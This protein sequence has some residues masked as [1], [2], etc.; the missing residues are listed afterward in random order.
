[1]AKPKNRPSPL[2][3]ANSIII[4]DVV[5]AMRVQAPLPESYGVSTSSEIGSPF[6]QY[7]TEGTISKVLALSGSST[8][9]GILTRK[10]FLA[11][12]QPDISFDMTFNAYDSAYRDVLI[13][14]YRLLLMSAAD[15]GTWDDIVAQAKQDNT[16]LAA[17]QGAEEAL[18]FGLSAAGGDS[19]IITNL[20]RYVRSPGLCNVRIGNVFTL[21]IV[22]FLL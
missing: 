20:I 7:A 17:I 19:K 22:I 8:K 5:Y 9:I 14:V 15:E 6:A 3:K 4:N 11:P 16:A 2:R 10:L 12:D 21:K 13:P 18:S 1:M